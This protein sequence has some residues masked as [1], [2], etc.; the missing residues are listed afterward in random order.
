MKP[1]LA[2]SLLLKTLIDL[3]TLLLIGFNNSE[4]GGDFKVLFKNVAD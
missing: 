1:D 3:N 2:F 4:L